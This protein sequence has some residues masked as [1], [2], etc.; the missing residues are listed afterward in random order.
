MPGTDT[1]N[2]GGGASGSIVCHWAEDESIKLLIVRSDWFVVIMLYVSV[3][4]YI[5]GMLNPLF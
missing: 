1:C 3:F 2:G 4:F 5:W